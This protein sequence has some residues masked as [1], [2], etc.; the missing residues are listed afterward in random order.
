[1][2]DRQLEVNFPIA[3]DSEVD[4]DEPVSRQLPDGRQHTRI[5]AYSPMGCRL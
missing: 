2:D 4:G 1:M 3:D 5:V